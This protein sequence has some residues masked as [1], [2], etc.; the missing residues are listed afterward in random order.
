MKKLAVVLAVVVSGFVNGQVNICRYVDSYD[1]CTKKLL[2][3][4]N[5]TWCSADIRDAYETNNLSKLDYLSPDDLILVDKIYKNFVL[6]HG[7]SVQPVRDLT[8]IISFNDYLDSKVN[9]DP[10]LDFVRFGD[11]QITAII[12]IKSLMSKYKSMELVQM[13]TL[14]KKDLLVIIHVTIFVQL[15]DNS[16]AIAN[17]Y[18]F[19]ETLDCA[20]C[21]TY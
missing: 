7:N 10:T 8:P 11:R 9:Y 12:P 20:Q 21:A 17:D 14:D 15:L 16:W 18:M 13:C 2:E 3:V 5:F 4:N 1:Q 19:D 6:V